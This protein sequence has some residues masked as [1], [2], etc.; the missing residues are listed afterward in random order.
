M[1]LEGAFLAIPVGARAREQ[2]LLQPFE[3]RVQDTAVFGPHPLHRA[4]ASV[5][6]HSPGTFP[7]P[8]SLSGVDFG[9]CEV[10]EVMGTCLV[11]TRKLPRSRCGTC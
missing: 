9:V 2:Q 4:A 6:L 10:R 11:W 7:L 5:L 3:L 8:R 1:P